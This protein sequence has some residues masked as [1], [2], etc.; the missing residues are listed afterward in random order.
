MKEH[1]SH[2]VTPVLIYFQLKYIKYID[3][4]VNRKTIELTRLTGFGPSRPHDHSFPMQGGSRPAGLDSAGP[5]G[6]SPHW[7]GHDPIV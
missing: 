1:G 2:F 7:R 4:E 5:R 6:R 3:L